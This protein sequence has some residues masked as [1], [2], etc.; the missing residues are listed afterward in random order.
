MQQVPISAPPETTSAC[1][2]IVRR[3]E[4]R[5]RL[6]IGASTLSAMVAAGKFPKPFPIFSGGRAVGWCEHEIEAWLQQRSTNGGE[7]A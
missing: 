2:R 6:G 3:A 4:V 7:I 5:K 1:S